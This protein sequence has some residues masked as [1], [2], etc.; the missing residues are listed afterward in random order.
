MLKVPRSLVTRRLSNAE[1][2]SPAERPEDRY[3]YDAFISYSRAADG[4]LARVLQHGLHTF[5][6]PWYRL[7]ALRVFRDEGSL[8]ASS[9]LWGSL[10]E[11]MDASRHFVLL[12]CEQSARAPWVEQEVEYWCTHRG[13]DHLVIVL[14]DPPADGSGHTPG[15]AWDAARGDFDWQRTNA[16]PRCLSGRFREEPNAV[17]LGRARAKPELSLRDP[18]F[19]TAVAAL[20]APLHGAP[21]DRLIGE[22]VRQYRRTRRHVLLTIAVLAA[23]VVLARSPP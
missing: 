13:V 5:A 11:A 10:R 7:R 21:K 1:P 20:A 2:V 12:A 3:A 19:R 17:V 4:E 6:K 22:D 18:E 23:L 15:M 8:A 14:T 16:L 9:Q